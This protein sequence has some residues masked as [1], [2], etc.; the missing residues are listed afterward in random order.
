MGKISDIFWLLSEFANVTT[1]LLVNREYDINKK[2]YRCF[3][4]GKLNNI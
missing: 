3:L 4:Q 1:L 2:S